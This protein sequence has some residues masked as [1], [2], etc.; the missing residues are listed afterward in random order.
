[1]NQV[2]QKLHVDEPDYPDA[3]QLGPDA[4]PHLRQLIAGSD[5]ML[6]SKAAYLAGLIADPAA[7]PV[8]EAAIKSPHPI[9]RVA[10]AATLG[11]HT[12]ATAEL[13]RQLLPDPDPGVRKTALRSLES[14][15]PPGLR[16]DVQKIADQDPEPLLKDLAKR[17]VPNLR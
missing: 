3:A 12:Q 8:I 1:M 6:A 13:F 14:R 7:L 4:L 10:A 16:A 2:M 11:N 15:K 9:V 17:L 5:A